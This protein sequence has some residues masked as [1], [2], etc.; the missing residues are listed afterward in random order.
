MTIHFLV[1]Y[2]IHASFSWPLE[3]IDSALG[4][5]APWLTKNPM[6]RLHFT[7]SRLRS[8][9]LWSSTIINSFFHEQ[10]CNGWLLDVLPLTSWWECITT[11]TLYPAYPCHLKLL[12]MSELMQHSRLACNQ[13]AQTNKPDN[14]QT[15]KQPCK[16]HRGVPSKTLGIATCTK[17]GKHVRAKRGWLIR[18]YFFLLHSLLVI[19]WCLKERARVP[20]ALP[21]FMHCHPQSFTWTGTCNLLPF[22]THSFN[23]STLPP[24]Y[25]LTSQQTRPVSLRCT[26]LCLHW[27]DCDFLP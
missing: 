14:K 20:G 5:E 15:W 11:H 10:F 6:L 25:F 23:P 8:Y 22:F 7:E 2:F 4:P 3:G 13:M 1:A 26:R 27:P 19:M 12:C 21:V 9:D 16:S 17:T 24:F 18:L